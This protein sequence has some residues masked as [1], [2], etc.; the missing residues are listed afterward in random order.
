MASASFSS[1]EERAVLILKRAVADAP[2]GPE[3]N[4]QEEKPSRRTTRKS[5]QEDWLLVL[6][7]IDS[8]A[9]RRWRHASGRRAQRVVKALDR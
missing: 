3:E 5:K 9:K 1:G 4:S 8:P 7:A 6:R 2:Q